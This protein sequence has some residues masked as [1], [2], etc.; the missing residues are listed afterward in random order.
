MRRAAAILATVALAARRAAA[1]AAGRRFAPPPPGR[2]AVLRQG[3]GRGQAAAGREAPAG[4]A[5]GRRRS[6]ARHGRSASPAA[7]LRMLMARATDTRMMV[8]YGYARLVA[9]TGTRPRA[10]HPEVRRRQ[11]RPH[12]HLPP[13]P[14]HMVGRRA[15]HRRG[16]P[17][18]LGGHRRRTR[19]VSP[20][21]AA[22]RHDGRRR[23][24]PSST[25]STRRPSATTGPSRT[26][27][28]CRRWPAP[29][30]LFIYKPAHYLKQFHAKYQDADK[31]AAMVKKAKRRNWA[32]LLNR[33]DEQYRNDNPDLPTLEPWVLKTAAAVAALRV[34]AQPVLSTASTA[35]GHQL[36][37]IDRVVMTSPTARS[38]R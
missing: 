32:A 9:T 17:L 16:F 6:T 2:D 34:R 8:V 26:P 11:G 19:S 36:P 1:A 33:M 38:C 13:A 23:A 31:L 14:G 37:Y 29:S 4:G 27:P 10:R 28:S 30:P 18:L 22:A 24:A 12:L 21:G 7:T 5:Q 20:S 35:T 15:L 25:S 3:C